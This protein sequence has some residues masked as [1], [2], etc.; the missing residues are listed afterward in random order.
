MGNDL[1]S[2]IVGIVLEKSGLKQKLN[3][4][5]AE[6]MGKSYGA[7]S[8]TESGSAV[9]NGKST[10]NKLDV[11]TLGSAKA[12]EGKL[13]DG[14]FAFVDYCENQDHNEV[15]RIFIM[16]GGYK[17]TATLNHPAGS[18]TVQLTPGMN[19]FQAEFSPRGIDS[20]SIDI[21]GSACTVPVN[22]DS[23]MAL[24]IDSQDIKDFNKD[25]VFKFAGNDNKEDISIIYKLSKKKSN[26]WQ[27]DEEIA[28]EAYAE[29]GTE[30]WPETTKRMFI[31]TTDLRTA[32]NTFWQWITMTEAAITWAEYRTTN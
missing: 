21:A 26:E 14:V 25:T 15:S 17:G 11:K 13:P 22:Y 5:F 1:F 24:S 19:P 9:K 18:E 3:D 29:D 20:I 30:Q 8:K 12:P 27:G 32:E 28:W 2:D 31:K 16:S 6:A 10:P 4:I 23:F 7:D